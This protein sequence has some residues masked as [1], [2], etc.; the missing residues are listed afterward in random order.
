MRSKQTNITVLLALWLVTIGG[1]TYVTFFKQPDELVKIDEAENALALDRSEF[2]NLALLEGNMREGIQF[3]THRWEARYKNIGDSLSTADV[4]GYVNRFAD[5]GFHSFGV[6]FSGLHSG[7]NHQYYSFGVRGSGPFSHLYDFVWQMENNGDLYRVEDLVIDQAPGGSSGD[8]QFTFRLL[9]YFGTSAAISATAVSRTVATDAAVFE[10]TDLPK[11]PD[12][13]LPARRLS[14]DPFAGAT[15]EPSAAE[16]GNGAPSSSGADL[17]SLRAAKLVSII[18]NVAM[19]DRSGSI[20]KVQA[21]DVV[22]EG[23]VVRIDPSRQ[24]VTVDGSSGEVH[25]DM[26]IEPLYRRFIGPKTAA[27]VHG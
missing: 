1:G 11:V 5:S 25:I 8:V 22:R 21:G 16:K 12:D 18:G 4:M 20:R 26:D 24:R 15:T 3:A 7:P 2:R 19:F 23:R 13:V 17:F 27:P 10:N 9:A 6:E 14:L